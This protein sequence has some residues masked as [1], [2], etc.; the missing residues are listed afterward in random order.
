MTN[1]NNAF[2]LGFDAHDDDPL[3]NVELQDSDF[4][5][6]T[7]EIF[8]AGLRIN[9]HQPPKI[10]SVLEGGYDLDAIARSSIKHVKVLKKGYFGIL[11]DEQLSRGKDIN[12]HFNGDAVDALNDYVSSLSL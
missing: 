4:E 11:E 12:L 1:S 7:E 9:P 2:L 8:K 5:W 3:S 10:I 6:A